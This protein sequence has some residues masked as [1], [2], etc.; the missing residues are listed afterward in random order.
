M[1]RGLSGWGEAET[2]LSITFGAGVGT[3]LLGYGCI[4][5]GINNELVI[6]RRLRRCVDALAWLLV[7]LYMVLLYFDVVEE[8]R[9]TWPELA[10]VRPIACVVMG[11]FMFFATTH[12]AFRW[13]SI[14]FLCLTIVC[15]T[16]AT[17]SLRIVIDCRS[18]STCTNRPA[19]SLLALEL[20]WI[21]NIAELFVSTVAWLTLAAMCVSM[22]WFHSRYP[23]R[24]FDGSQPMSFVPVSSGGHPWLASGLS[25]SMQ[26]GVATF[27]AMS[28]DNAARGGGDGGGSASGDTNASGAAAR[29]AQAGVPPARASASVN[30]VGVGGGYGGTSGGVRRR[31]QA[32]GSNGRDP[33]AGVRA[34]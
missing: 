25:Q 1:S 12:P 34:A 15:N 30:A 32:G 27:N 20:Q 9:V 4:V 33:A 10:L 18:A 26:A 3:F 16:L 31:Q 19:F 21:R 28:D 13:I 24:M 11:M 7:L 6:I 29:V 8:A 17:A 2:V 22:G 23:P 5:H 14:L